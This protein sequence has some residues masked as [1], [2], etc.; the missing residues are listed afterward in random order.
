MF[1]KK[2][3]IL[4]SENNIS[5]KYN[6][7]KITI[8]FSC[9]KVGDKLPLLIICKSKRPGWIKDVEDFID[10][11]VYE[12]SP[13]AWMKKKIFENCLFSLDKNFIAQNIKILMIFDND[14]YNLIQHKLKNIEHI[15][16]KKTKLLRFSH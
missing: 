14:P 9:N 3:L 8:M 6:K 10:F 12:S 2:S 15:F 16:S 5:E 13:K 11:I 1:A 4:S 7:E